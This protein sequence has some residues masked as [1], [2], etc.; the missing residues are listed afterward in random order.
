MMTHT[1]A[2]WWANLAPI[3]LDELIHTAPMLTRVDRKYVL[4][5]ADLDSVLAGLDPA[6]RVLMIDQ[7]APQ[8]YQSLYFDT[9]EYTSFLMAARG[10][11]RKFKIRTRTY[12]N[13]NTSFVELKAQGPRGVTVK[14]RV[15]CP[16][17]LATLDQDVCAWLEPKLVA[18]GQPPGIAARLVPTL[19]GGYRRTTLLMADGSGRATVDT[20]LTW[21]TRSGYLAR[22]ALAI[23]ETKS[24][25][26]PSTVDR[27]LWSAGYRPARISKFGTGMAALDPT[28]PHNR[29]NRVLSTYFWT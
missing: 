12:V 8:P 6:T 26:R 25:S 2:P 14:E 27:L 13:S 17:G 24:G 21:A 18:A 23:V 4:N 20:D 22:P 5:R 29:W 3:S 19:W 1:P 11:R 16:V 10:R 28:L 15:P 9:P 7:Q